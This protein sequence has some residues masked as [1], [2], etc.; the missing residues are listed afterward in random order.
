M[1]K[2]VLSLLLALAAVLSLAACGSSETAGGE[3]TSE[4]TTASIQDTTAQFSFPETTIIDNEHVTFKITAIDEDNLWGYT[5]KAYLE[6]KTGQDLMFSLSD[7]SANGFMCDPF[8]ATTVA[9]GMKA[10]EE[11]SFSGADFERSGI[12][13]VTDIEFTLDVYDANDWSAEHLV[14]DVFSVYPQ[15]EEAVRT[16]ERAPQGSDI[17]LFDNEDCAMIVTGFDPDDAFGYTVSVYLVNKT[18]KSLMF[19]LSDAAVNGF[20]CDPYWAQ[21]VA[22]GKVSF[23]SITWYASTLEENGITKVESLT[24]PIRVYDANDWMAEDLVNDTFTVNP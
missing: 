1:K 2:K 11:I 23:T 5:L 7:V 4:E 13:T 10:N 15:G 9:A 20:M 14:S 21:T 12:T 16:Y 19:S 22:P 8:W 24:L 18:D 17:V 6:N 3:T